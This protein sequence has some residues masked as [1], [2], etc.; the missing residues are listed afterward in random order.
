MGATIC[1]IIRHERLAPNWIRMA[2]MFGYALSAATYGLLLLGCVT[3]WRRRLSGSALTTAFGA[4][5]ASSTVLAVQ[6]AEGGVALPVLVASQYL[7]SL[8]WSAV[9]VRCL[10][11]SATGRLE[12]RV[13]HAL[14]AALA[15]LLLGTFACVEWSR[16]PLV[17][18]FARHYWVWGGLAMSI[19]GLVLVEQVARNMRSA[20]EWAFKQVWL[21]IGGIFAWDLCVDSVSILR[22]SAVPAFW[23][24]RGF[25][26]AM[27]GGVMAVGLRRV[28]AWQAAAFLSPRLGFFNAALLGTA[29]YVLAMWTSSV[30]IRDVGGSWGPAGQVVLLAAGAIAL[31]VAVLSDQIRA[32]LRVTVAKSLFLYRYDY[33]LEWR[34]LTRA[35]SERSAIP[36][37]ERI[38]DV[39][40]RS[41]NCACG[42]LWLHDP[43]GGYV[44]AGGELASSGAPR[45]S[46]S[47]EFFEYL[48]RR[49]WICDLEVLR[50]RPGSGPRLDPPAWMLGN[51]RIWLIVPLICQDSLVGFVAI[52]QPLAETRLTWEEFDL[53]RAAGRQVASYLAFEQAAKRLAEAHQFEAVNRISAL[54]MH[55]LR[56]LIQQ[57]ALVVENA[58]R[59]RGNPEF[60]D[61]A[62][63]TIESSV[64][65]MTR[66]M[67]ELRSGALAE[68]AHHVELSELTGEVARRCRDR[69]PVP[70]SAALER[71]IEVVLNRDRML[72]VL[73][74]V[75]RNA[76]DATPSDGR[77]TLSVRR[78]GQR[79]VV[80]VTDT[81]SGM[82]AEFIR[83]RLFSPFDTT[84]G[85]RGMGIGA[86]E[87]REFIRGC[88][89][90]IEVESAL[91]K[92]TTFIIRLPLAP[93]LAAAQMPHAPAEE[94]Q[95]H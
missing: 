90:N 59:H 74:H 35:L 33:R 81:G 94:L 18:E 53:L 2:A 5:V 87:V 10:E 91:G 9:L 43:E 30:F 66:L 47:R 92:G 46:G 40:A 37:H 83:H 26:Y 42:G 56:H 17:E 52:G 70:Q 95:A 32:R 78:A 63:L 84:K 58:G 19:G 73:E 41:V 25:V 67:D 54:L 72:Q 29:M 11:A 85:D 28:A 51:L 61:D 82:D 1:K 24:A 79:A 13:L 71:G 69:R 7:H 15:L 34:K 21:A 76:Q 31:A 80:E 44:P 45:E 64:R 3:V 12:R 36:V 62:I 75:V 50:N 16:S 65:R 20:H 77:I 88:G 38:V 48:L 14:S 39:M 4:Q 57:Q 23:H 89:G 8:A 60:F 6:T 27:L 93:S 22:G 55:D 68:Q 49:E 86:Y